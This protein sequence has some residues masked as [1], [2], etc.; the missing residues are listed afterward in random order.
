ML[1][2]CLVCPVV[3]GLSSSWAWPGL[4][5]WWVLDQPGWEDQDCTMGNAH[6]SILAY[7]FVQN[8]RHVVQT[9][10]LL[11]WRPWPCLAGQKSGQQRL[12]YVYVEV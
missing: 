8:L 7:I 9:V 11:E 2:V 4:G 5:A 3:G 6:V 12:P 10:A 1:G